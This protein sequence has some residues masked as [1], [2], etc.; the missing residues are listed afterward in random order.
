M[1]RETENFLEMV[2]MKFEF[3][4][5]E[6]SNPKLIEQTTGVK[7]TGYNHESYKNFSKVIKAVCDTIRHSHIE[8]NENL[9]IEGLQAVSDGPLMR[10]VPEP[11]C[12]VKLYRSELDIHPL[13]FN[14]QDRILAIT[15]I[16]TLWQNA[17]MQQADP[18]A[19]VR[20][21]LADHGITS[22]QDFED[23]KESLPA[24]HNP[25]TKPVNTNSL[26]Y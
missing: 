17:Y 3:T 20:A 26:E 10:F 21:R 18:E 23:N 12:A 14:E 15:Y 6:L 2:V 24:M 13:V 22:W 16:L 4:A 1:S 19:L 5:E 25:F 11:K 7:F 8:L 9:T